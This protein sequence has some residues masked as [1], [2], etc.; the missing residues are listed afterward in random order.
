MTTTTPGLRRGPA[1]VDARRRGGAAGR[2]LA[3]A[4]SSQRGQCRQPRPES[5][6]E[7]GLRPSAR[8]RSARA[9]PNGPSTRFGHHAGCAPGGCGPSR[10][11]PLGDRL[12]QVHHDVVARRSPRCRRRSRRACRRAR[13]SARAP[14]PMTRTRGRRPGIENFCWIAIISGCGGDVVRLLVRHGLAELGDRLLGDPARQFAS[15][16][17]RSSGRA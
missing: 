3:A 15:A 9:T 6:T 11:V 17:T 14:A 10:V 5:G 4:R 2:R 8:A 16:G 13:R 7:G 1:G 12:G